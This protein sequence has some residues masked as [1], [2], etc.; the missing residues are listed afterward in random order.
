MRKPRP[1]VY[2]LSEVNI[3]R[4][5]TS[6]HI[7]YKDPDF[8]ATTLTIGEAIQNMSDQEIVDLYNDT[9]K[10]QAELARSCKYVAVEPPL[11]TPQINYH[12]GCDQWCPS[13]DVLR[14]LI[15]DT[16]EGEREPVIH[17]DDKE[18]SWCEFGKLICT[19]AGW[20]MRIEFTPEDATHRRP[21]L[22]VRK[23]EKQ[24]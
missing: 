12:P 4:D 6:A 8:G 5:K 9:L 23:P 14:C 13:G 3:T 2:N 1:L 7:Q 19:Y 20:G 22:E 15:D 11:G 24:G 16:A 17:I 10:G 18:L 21:K